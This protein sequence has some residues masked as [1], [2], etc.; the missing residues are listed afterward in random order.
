MQN[1]RLGE[2]SRRHFACCEKRVGGAFIVKGVGGSPPS[3][4]TKASVLWASE[5]SKKR[6]SIFSPSTYSRKYRPK[7]SVEILLAKAVGWPRRARPTATLNGDPPGCIVNPTVRPPSSMGKKSISISPMHVISP[8]IGWPSRL[9]ERCVRQHPSPRTPA[10]ELNTFQ[11][12][13]AVA[14]PSRA[15]DFH[16]FGGAH[17]RRKYLDL[18]TLNVQAALH[19]P[20]QIERIEA[21]VAH[22]PQ[23]DGNIMRAHRVGQYRLA[24]GINSSHGHAQSTGGKLRGCRVSICYGR[25]LH[26][27]PLRVEA[28]QLSA[29]SYD[30]F[31]VGGVC[32]QVQLFCAVRHRLPRQI[33]HHAGAHTRPAQE[34]R[35]RGHAVHIAASQRFLDFGQVRAVNV[36]THHS[37]SDRHSLA[38]ASRLFQRINS[39]HIA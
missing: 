30:T 31:Y 27:D 38:R 19:L 37:P 9:R 22:P 4:A 25:D 3:I 23:V 36:E 32:L 28:R 34:G 2:K 21:L 5:E 15:R 26:D 8:F 14:T 39:L 29:F 17:A 33:R 7:R 12:R 6:V 16:L 20:H 35:I 11:G 18:A 10:G 1:R 13:V 24:H